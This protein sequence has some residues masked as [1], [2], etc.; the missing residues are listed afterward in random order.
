MRGGSGDDGLIQRFQLAVWPDC[1]STWRNVDRWPDTTSKPKVFDLVCRLDEMIAEEV[2][3]VQ[4]EDDEFPYLRFAPDAQAVFNAWLTKL[5]TVF[6][7]MNYFRDGKS[8]G[9]VSQSDP[10]LAP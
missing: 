6:A 5:E 3:A 9:E 7:V 8:L 10:S 1:P 4:S 2:G